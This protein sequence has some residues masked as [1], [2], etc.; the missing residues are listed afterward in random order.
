MR[1]PT[2][3]TAQIAASLTPLEQIEVQAIAADLAELRRENP[4]ITLPDTEPVKIWLLERVGVVW[5]FRA[6]S[7]EWADGPSGRGIAYRYP[8]AAEGLQLAEGVGR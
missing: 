6:C 2:Y 7:W 5:N 8:A 1:Y 4:L 3:T